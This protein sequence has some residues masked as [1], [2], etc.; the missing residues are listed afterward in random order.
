MVFLRDVLQVFE[1]GP[2][3]GFADLDVL[4]VEE[5]EDFVDEVAVDEFST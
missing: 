2:H 4:I 1:E 3:H 5:L